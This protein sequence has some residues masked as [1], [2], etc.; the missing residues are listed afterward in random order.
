MAA[1]KRQRFRAPAAEQYLAGDESS[2]DRLTQ[3]DIVRDEQ[4]DSGQ[5]K[6]LAKR[7]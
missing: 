6:C 2:L 1:G 4:I 5:P 7:L 3:P